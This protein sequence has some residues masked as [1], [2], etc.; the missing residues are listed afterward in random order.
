[1]N[2][3][4]G[5]MGTNW[6]RSKFAIKNIYKHVLNIYI[7]C[8]YS[9]FL[10]I[11]IY[12]WMFFQRITFQRILC[13]NPFEKKS[14][15]D[16]HC[17]KRDVVCVLKYNKHTLHSFLKEPCYS[18]YK[19]FHNTTVFERLKKTR[20]TPEN[21]LK[22]ESL[23]KPLVVIW[24]FH[25]SVQMFPI[26]SRWLEEKKKLAKHQLF[27]INYYLYDFLWILRVVI[28]KTHILLPRPGSG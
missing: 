25:K 17:L 26:R 24:Y 2:F 6:S 19:K 3:E 14:W 15:S 21:L 16:T 18:N 7:Y 12:N 27:G 20:N 23:A 5:G 22:S 9:F 8:I 10:Y 11:Y 1:M 4:E 13:K 28:F